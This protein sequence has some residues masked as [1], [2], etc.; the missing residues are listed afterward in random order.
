MLTRRTPEQRRPRVPEPSAAEAVG[1]G[2]GVGHSI[3]F[4]VGPGVGPDFD[5]GAD[6]D[7]GADG[8]S[9]TGSDTDTD[10]DTGTGSHT[11]TG[12]PKA[13]AHE[14]VAAL[15]GLRFLAASMVLCFHYLGDSS[16]AWRKWLWQIFPTAHAVASYGFL[17]VEFFFLIS[18]YVIC[19]SSW[20][21]GLG[22][23]FASRI[24]RLY[25]AYWAAVVVTA[26]L[27][28]WNPRYGPPLHRSEFLMN[29]TMVEQAFGIRQAD[30][31]Y[32]TLWVELRFY[33]LFGLVVWR[34]VTYRRV[35]A[36]CLLWTAATVL[37]SAI[38]LPMLHLIVQD[39][40]SPYF[41][42]GIAMYLM[43]RY[44]PTALLWCLVG[45]SWLLA[46]NRMTYRVA[47]GRQE[48]GA[49]LTW[50]TATLLV[51]FFYAAVLMVA[52]G[53]LDRVRRRW[54]T[55][56]GA[57]TYPLYLVHEALGL[58]LIELLHAKMSPWSLVALATA[59]SVLLAVLIRY[60]VER[61]MARPLR[62]AVERSFR[63]ISPAEPV[64]R[65]SGRSKP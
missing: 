49:H 61:P 16:W 22:G 26:F 5:F 19:M 33:L 59:S 63:E 12:R 4:S 44:R 58:D 23:Y 42:A 14:R 51:T 13:R 52:L 9:D 27:L 36:F 29:L 25:P 17:G 2:H 46:Q 41:I 21:R 65:L 64:P 56:V 24:S 53:R 62:H 11:G 60:L 35:V 57:L 15:D 1:A 47:E 37:A 43:R 40:F 32:W 10:T 3:G 45:F 7:F 6:V 30:G 31:V 48:T 54:L 34:G 8:D 28:V 39:D 38:N 55:V 20:G 50:G 18:G